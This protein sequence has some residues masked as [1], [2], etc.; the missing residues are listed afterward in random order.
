[1]VDTFFK[2]KNNYV[3]FA[4]FGCLPL[5]LSRKSP[6]GLQQGQPQRT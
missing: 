1:M 4:G 3:K 2:K 6:E 5:G